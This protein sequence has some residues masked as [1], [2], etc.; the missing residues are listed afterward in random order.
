[1]AICWAGFR[2]FPSD[3]FLCMCFWFLFQFLV[4]VHVSYKRLFCVRD[5][6]RDGNEYVLTTWLSAP[7]RSV[8]VFA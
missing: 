4:H 2:D 3:L 5:E 6:R 7:L 8:D 1:M